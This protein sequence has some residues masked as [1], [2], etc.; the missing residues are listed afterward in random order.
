METKFFASIV[1]V[2]ALLAGCA[3]T[4]SQYDV[5]TDA[6]WAGVAVGK[7]TKD[8][9]LATFGPP[10]ETT[11][12]RL[13]DLQVWSYRYRQSGIW[14]SMMHIHFDHDGVVREMLSGPDPEREERRFGR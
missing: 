1:I 11:Y 5:R 7:A 14:Y 10:D 2:A 4:P 3:A 12:L 6:A 13:R 8:N 9:I